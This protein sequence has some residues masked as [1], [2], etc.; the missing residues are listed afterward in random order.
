MLLKLTTSRP[1]FRENFPELKNIITGDFLSL[2]IDKYFSDKI[3]IIG[4]PLQY[5]TQIF[6]RYSST[7]KR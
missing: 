7:G 4:F 1:L 2:E 3:A 6:L 5:S